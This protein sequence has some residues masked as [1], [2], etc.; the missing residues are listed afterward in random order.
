MDNIRCGENIQRGVNLVAGWTSRRVPPWLVTLA[1][2]EFAVIRPGYV[3]QRFTTSQWVTVRHSLLLVHRRW[4]RHGWC[5][6]ALATVLSSL[7]D[8][9][10]AN[11]NSRATAPSPINWAHRQVRRVVTHPATKSCLQ[12]FTR[13]HQFQISPKPAFRHRERGLAVASS[14]QVRSYPLPSRF[15]VLVCPWYSSTNSI[16]LSYLRSSGTHQN[17]CWSYGHHGQSELEV[18]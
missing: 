5:H 9:H 15:S 16:E 2:P 6:R 3:P 17:V 7:F 14:S 11:P 13:A 8:R 18:Q 4:G 12:F 10:R 1:S